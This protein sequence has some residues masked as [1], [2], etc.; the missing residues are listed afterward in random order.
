MALAHSFLSQVELARIGF[1]QLGVDLKISRNAVFYGVEFISIGDQSRIDDF[2]II[3]ASDTGEVQI[4]KFVHLGVS[5]NLFGNS[6]ITIGDYSG[7]SPG[8]KLFSESDDFSGDFLTNPT[9]QK[10]LRNVKSGSIEL[11]EHSIIGSTCVVLPGVFIGEG[12]AVGALSLVN[13]SLDKW[14]IYSGVPARKLKE[15]NRGLLELKAA[16]FNP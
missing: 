5:V 9:I 10:H 1:K 6:G 12:A 3:S 2:S 14:C 11:G 16:H 13:K 7:I 4:G 15:R 8:T